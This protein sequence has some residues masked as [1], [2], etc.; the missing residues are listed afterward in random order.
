MTVSTK[1]AAPLVLTPLVELIR[2]PAQDRREVAAG[3]PRARTPVP[4]DPVD[5]DGADGQAGDHEVEALRQPADVRDLGRVDASCAGRD[6]DG[7]DRVVSVAHRAILA[8]AR[9]TS[10]LTPAQPP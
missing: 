9:I 10:R 7:A 5:Q 6:G 3:L 2:E 8:L 1:A 4:L